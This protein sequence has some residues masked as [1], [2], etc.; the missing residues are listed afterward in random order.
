MLAAAAA[1]AAFAPV[2]AAAAPAGPVQIG[3]PPSGKALIVFFRRWE[4]AGFVLSYIVREG[5]AELGVLGAGNYF[6]ATVDPGLHT[7]S[8]HAE[9][10]DDMQIQVEADEIYYVVFE[11]D[12]GLFLYQP[13]L[14]PT[15]Q[16]LFD[17]LSPRLKLSEPV[18]GP[19]QAIAPTAP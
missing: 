9:R 19:K 1:A 17:E 15:E 2:A 10:R 13:T 8:T 5:Q 4:Y 11:M 6:V 16:R 12:M 7:Y 18:T 14:V 3:D